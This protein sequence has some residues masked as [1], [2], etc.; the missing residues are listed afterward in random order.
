MGAKEC[1]LITMIPIKGEQQSPP[2]PMSFC[3]VVVE[4]S[5]VPGVFFC[6]S[7][8]VSTQWYNQ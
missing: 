1:L 3:L 8:E 7:A 5:N 6:H 4:G 2:N